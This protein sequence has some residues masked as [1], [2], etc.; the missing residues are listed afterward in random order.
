MKNLAA[1]R[2]ILVTGH[3][4]RGKIKT[5]KAD[6]KCKGQGSIS[7]CPSVNMGRRPVLKDT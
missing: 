2:V 5:V 6:C 4:L 7:L 1:S 3:G